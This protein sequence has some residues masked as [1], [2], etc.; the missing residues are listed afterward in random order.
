LG[1][2]ASSHPDHEL[3]AEAIRALGRIGENSLTPLTQIIDSG[4]F[5][6]VGRTGKRGGLAVMCIERQALRDSCLEIG[7]QAIPP[8]IEIFLENCPDNFF[9]TDWTDYDEDEDG[10]QGEDDDG[11]LV[12]HL[13]SVKGSKY[14][15]A[16]EILA[17]FK[18]I[19]IPML[20]EIVSQAGILSSRAT[21]RQA[22]EAKKLLKLIRRNIRKG[23]SMCNVSW[24]YKNVDDVI[25]SFLNGMRYP[26]NPIN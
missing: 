15:I 24:K 2:V 9:G 17:D 7:E 22:K 19:V 16:R 25:L 14:F 23:E 4:D 1:K 3:R 26:E 8:L 12:P 11:N 6:I 20:K 13:I 21:K 18:E 5:H 10:V